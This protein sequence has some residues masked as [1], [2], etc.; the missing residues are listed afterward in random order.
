MFAAPAPA[1]RELMIQAVRL[2][3]R[4]DRRP[5]PNPP[6]GAIVARDGEVIGRGA[7]QGPGTAHAEVLA[8]REAGSRARGA[9]L[10]CTLEPCNHQGR[11][12][13]CVPAVLAS[14]VAR[15]V[16]AVR[17]PNPT[18]AGGGLERL[19]D[20]GIAVTLGV[21]ADDAIE[22]IWPFVVTGAF[23]RPFVCLKTA[24]SL[25]GRFAPAARRERAPVYVTSELARHEVHVL[26][27]WSDVVLVGGETMRAD[28]PRLD[29]RMVTSEDACPA[30]DPIPAVATSGEPGDEWTGRRHVVFTNRRSLNPIP[31][32]SP[33]KSG[34]ALRVVECDEC[35]GGIDPASILEQLA[36]L[37]A[38]TLLVEGGPRLAASFLEAGVVDRWVSY[39]APVVLGSGP[40]WPD[41][42]IGKE[43]V[44]DSISS[45]RPEIE[46]GTV[47]FTLTRVARCGPD[48][49]AVWDRVP[50]AAT[51]DRLTDGS[52]SQVPASGG[53]A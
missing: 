16:V 48:L 31:A 34:Q 29:T 15:V 18:V 6:V 9:T 5:W 7:H 28:A 12:P 22:L 36:G 44:P 17:D 21:C 40:R 53:G 20:G 23:V 49:K 3:A 14:G 46:S 13:P 32:S 8:L 30:C 47:S 4:I 33:E 52:A 19:L 51:R 11:T 35:E 24:T 45:P 37:D 2:A 27:R 10:Y 39:T 26:R 50:F 41:F 1:D 42:A 25:D 38:F 43:A